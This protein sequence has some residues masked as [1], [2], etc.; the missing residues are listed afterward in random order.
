MSMRPYGGFSF[1]FSNEAQ[2]SQAFSTFAK[3]LKKTMPAWSNALMLSG[4][5][6]SVDMNTDLGD[7]YDEETE[8]MAYRNGTDTLLKICK[9]LL[10]NNPE[11]VF[12]LEAKTM[13]IEGQYFAE[14]EAKN[15][16]S[17]F[18]YHRSI[19][20]GGPDYDDLDEFGADED[21]D[22][23]EEDPDG[24]STLK[25]ELTISGTFKEGK[26]SFKKKQKTTLELNE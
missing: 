15:D 16:S 9:I 6:I 24:E 20:I 13:D 3:E 19:E 5:T 7:E 12:K 23:D 25:S 8:R 11:N 26:W 14:E 21:I 18:T 17:G 10:N 1:S 2:A 22:L 4:N